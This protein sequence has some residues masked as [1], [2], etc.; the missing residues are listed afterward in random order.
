[1]ALSQY[2]QVHQEVVQHLVKET[3]LGKDLDKVVEGLRMTHGGEFERVSE[4]VWNILLGEAYDKIRMVRKGAGATAYGVLKFWF[5]D[6]S[7]LGLAE[8]ARMLMHPSPLKKEEELAEYVEMWQDE[9]R[10]LEAHGED[11]KLAPLFKI[12]DLRMLMTGN[13][14]EYF[15]LWEADHDPTIAKKTYEELLNRVKDYA[16]R[17]KLDT[18]AKESI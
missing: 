18:A 12:N 7:G 2:D 10:G 17:R 3:D 6:G 5:T 13:A 1:M 4:D 15:D 16:R 11:F 8:Q 14:R 9:M